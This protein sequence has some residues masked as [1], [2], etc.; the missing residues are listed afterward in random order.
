[1]K[2]EDFRIKELETLLEEL[3][4]RL[5]AANAFE[6]ASLSKEIRAVMS[7]LAGLKGSGVSYHVDE[8]GGRRESKQ[9]QKGKGGVQGK[10]ATRN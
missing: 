9:R 1:M 2:E 6:T 8:L 10:R 5:P 4:A 3:T 7:E